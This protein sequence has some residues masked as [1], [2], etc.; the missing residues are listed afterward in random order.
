M[1]GHCLEG[2]HLCIYKVLQITVHGKTQNTKS[3]NSVNLLDKIVK[4]YRSGQGHKLFLKCSQEH[5]GL[6][7]FEM[8]Q[9]GLFSELADGQTE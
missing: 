2:A 5:G 9:V 4:R 6:N 7:N 3:T 1:T 8:E